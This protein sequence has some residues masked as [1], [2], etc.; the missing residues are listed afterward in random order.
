MIRIT[1]NGKPREL[2]EAVDLATFLRAHGRDPRLV[3]AELNGEIIRITDY[4]ATT[5][6]HGDVLELAHM[7]AGGGQSPADP[8]AARNPAG[9]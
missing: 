3:V 9:P 8:T 1:V 5:L 7:V 2:E 6:Q 4:G